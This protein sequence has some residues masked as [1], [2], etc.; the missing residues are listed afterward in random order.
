MNVMKRKLLRIIAV[1]LLVST[2][3]GLCSSCELIDKILGKNQNSD[4]GDEK[5]A[6]LVIFENG[7]YNCEFIYP[8]FSDATMSEFRNELRAA[9]KAKTGISPSFKGD[10]KVDADAEVFEVLIGDTNRPESAAPADVVENSDSYYGVSVVGKKIVIHGSDSYQLGVALNYFIE[11]YLSGDV[12]EK[13]A[14]PGGLSEVKILKG[15]TR[16]GWKLEGIPAYPEGVGKLI[17]SAYKCGTTITD[18]STSNRNNS[19]VTLQKINLSNEEE[20]RAYLAKVES[21]GFKKEYENITTESYFLT[22][23]SADQRIHVSF[24]PRTG[25]AQV[26][27][28]PK[29]ISIEEFGYS[30]T[31][32][33]GERSEYYLYGLPMSDGK[34]NNHP[35]CGT[36]SII[37]CADNSV[38]IIDG[39][40]YDG[41][42]G[43]QMYGEEVMGA[44]DDFLHQI[45]GTADGDKVRISAWFVTHYH[46]DHVMGFREF[47]KIYYANYDLERVIANIPIQDCGGSSNPFP[48]SVTNYAYG[49]LDGWR[50]LIEIRYPNCKEIK[51][52]TGQKIQIADVTLDVIYTHEDLLNMSA[53]FS[54][55]DSN[56][57]STCIRV[58][59][60]QMSMVVLG[61][62]S[63][64]SEARIRSNF[65]EVTLKSDIIQPAH[66][67]IYAI[68]DIF[69]E[70]QP[71]YAM[72][73]QAR[74][75]MGSSSTLPNQGS[76]KDRDKKLK[77]LVAEEN[78]YFAGNESVGFAVVDGK[79]ERIYY[80]EGVVGR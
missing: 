9:F 31:P 28:D 33:A 30:Y 18:L 21:Y 20:F 73:T 24:K 4:N 71:T 13:V 57:T 26:I 39:G 25:E 11:T 5:V 1:I 59:N 79:I 47:L 34:G 55:S 61:D 6:D 22:Y 10:D 23:K 12:A 78:C 27:S 15:F 50:E 51:V 40:A 49:L 63:Q 44:F 54:S 41:D 77:E 64:S 37:K 7:K 35:N 62:A 72:V 43:T 69:K 70:V 19:D 80:V 74:E 65:T 2:M 32:A 75:V 45:T 76:Y 29:G 52:H 53:R 42:G 16:E 58:D 8:G 60:G 67:L 66:H 56:D 14:V 48:T 38:I 68:F 36:L 46:A 17:A 3:V